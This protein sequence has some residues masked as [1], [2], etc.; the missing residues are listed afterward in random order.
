M[1]HVESF[2]PSLAGVQRLYNIIHINCH[3]TDNPDIRD[4]PLGG[5]RKA[6]LQIRREPDGTWILE[7]VSGERM[8]RLVEV[9]EERESENA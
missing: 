9:P 4:V 6:A 2:L 1:L 7:S 8:S 3:D 5:G